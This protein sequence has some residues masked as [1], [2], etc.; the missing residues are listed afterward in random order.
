MVAHGLGAEA[1]GGVRPATGIGKNR[2]GAPGVTGGATPAV[3][4]TGPARRRGG[5]GI[6]AP[7]GG[8]SCS[9]ART[10]LASLIQT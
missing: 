4:Q 10:R 2:F 1:V 5:T 8:L 6:A 3:Q 7:F 9:R